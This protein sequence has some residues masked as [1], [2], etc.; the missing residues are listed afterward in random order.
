MIDPKQLESNQEIEYIVRS[1]FQ[2]QDPDSSFIERLQIELADRFKA[3]G[4]STIRQNIFFR[5][6][7]WIGKI[8]LLISPL[9]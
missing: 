2:I 4:A 9:A 5:R 8:K 6:S 1:A 3:A 7:Q